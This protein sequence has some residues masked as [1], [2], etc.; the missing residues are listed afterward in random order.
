MT[1]DCGPLYDALNLFLYRS[2]AEVASMATARGGDALTRAASD[3]LQQCQRHFHDAS[4]AARAALEALDACA[5]RL[6]RASRAAHGN[7]GA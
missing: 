7:P 3:E 6:L 5:A 2:E 4:V 1:M